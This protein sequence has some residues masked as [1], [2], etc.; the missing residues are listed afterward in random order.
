MLQQIKHFMYHTKLF[1]PVVTVS[2]ENDKK[3]L[4]QLRT[5]FKRTIKW[6]KYRLGMNNQTKN[7][8]FSYLTDLSKQIE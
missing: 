5:E 8:N 1:V 2:T 4:E 7:N 3:L 6:N